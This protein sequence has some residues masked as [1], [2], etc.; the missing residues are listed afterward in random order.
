M[1]C[2]LIRA[3]Q[4]SVSLVIRHHVVDPS[5]PDDLHRHLLQLCSYHMEVLSLSS[6]RSG[7]VNGEV[8]ILIY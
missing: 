5:D 3:L 2:A 6:G 7:S 4:L 8:R 1:L